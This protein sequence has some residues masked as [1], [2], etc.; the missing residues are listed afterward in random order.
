VLGGV[1][2]VSRLSPPLARDLSSVQQNL[3]ALGR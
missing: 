3:V 1:G 2:L